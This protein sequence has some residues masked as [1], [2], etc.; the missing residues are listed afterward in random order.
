MANVTDSAIIGAMQAWLDD[1]VIGHNFCPFARFVRQ[2]DT[3]YYTVTRSK[4]VQ[5]VMLA[6]HAECKRLDEQP[7]IST[8]LLMVPAFARFTGYLD[9]LDLAHAML[10][11]WQYE[12]VYQ[13][14]S[15]HP[16]YQFEG[17]PANAPSH[18]T[19]RSPY[20]TLHLIREDDITRALED[21]PDPEAIFERNMAVTEELGSDYFDKQ[22]N[23]CIHAQ[24]KSKPE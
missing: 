22:L 20:P 17:E 9:M 12:G 21:Y 15:F 23:R 18:Y 1:I 3:I 19:N 14:A 11:Q 16:D 8:T 5:D 13:L 2:P 4:D 10:S 24:Q 7:D 6:L